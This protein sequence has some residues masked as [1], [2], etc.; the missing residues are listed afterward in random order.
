MRPAR[1]GRPDYPTR[2]LTRRTREEEG[3]RTS[4]AS[5][6]SSDRGRATAAVGSVWPRDGRGTILPGTTTIER[7][8]A[9]AQRRI[10]ARIA[11]QASSHNSPHST[12]GWF[13]PRRRGPRIA[14]CRPGHHHAMVRAT[15]TGRAIPRATHTRREV[16]KA[17]PTATSSRRAGRSGCPEPS[18]SASPHD[19]ARF[20][21][22]DAKDRHPQRRSFSNERG[23]PRL[24]TGRSRP[25]GLPTRA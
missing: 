13:F 7:L 5:D 21:R 14:R 22:F 23:D 15:E 4:D 19:R 6:V 8:Y 9:D 10:E 25:A 11:E 3:S 17:H 20:A 16:G 1:V 18:T 12:H 24:K 2:E